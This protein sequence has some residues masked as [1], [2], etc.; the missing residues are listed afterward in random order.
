MTMNKIDAIELLIKLA[1]SGDE[2][3]NITRE[4]VLVLVEKLE[5]E[6]AQA[7][8]NRTNDMPDGSTYC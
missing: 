1:D 3:E 8:T 6:E 4:G 2:S 5:K 7:K